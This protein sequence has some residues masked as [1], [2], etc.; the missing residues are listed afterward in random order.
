MKA[1]MRYTTHADLGGQPGY[2]AVTPDAEGER[3]H[4]AWEPRALA[5]TLAM[6][7]TGAWNIDMSRAARETLPDYA[8][9]TYYRIWLAA[10]ENL[11]EAHGYADAAE[12]ASGCVHMPPR[13]VARV[14]HAAEVADALAR[15][16]PTARPAE[17][18]ARFKREDRV[19]MRADAPHHHTRLPCYVR[20]HIGTIERV[21]GAHVF[22]DTH[23]HGL[24]EQ[25]RWLYN[26]AFDEAELWPDR[27][28]QGLRVSVDAWEPY[29][30]A[31]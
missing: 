24:G 26:V 20:G 5:L 18:P 16:S 25:P 22:A 4:A 11:L 15:G 7:A 28:P 2:G 29:L 17:L 6:G 30:E 19:R 31:T 8:A 13:A 12:I 10:L 21:H 23:A 3:F 14:L 27:A 9:L 1:A